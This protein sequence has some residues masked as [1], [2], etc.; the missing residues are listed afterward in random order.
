MRSLPDFFGRRFG[1]TARRILPLVLFASLAAWPAALTAT[2][3]A[4][5]FVAARP[6][7]TRGYAS[8]ARTRVAS[9]V[10]HDSGT[11]ETDTAGRQ[12]VHLLEVDTDNRAVSFEASVSN[13]RVAGLETTT[14]QANRKSAGG[15]RAVAAV[16]ADFWG[17]L[18]APIGIHIQNG[19]LI[20]SPLSARPA[21]GVK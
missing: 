3:R 8:E 5:K 6:K 19:E 10:V 1:L 2:G 16:N 4:R 9:G 21:F 12:V 20:T 15:R 11:I 7:V 18:E 14:A 17:P 13:D